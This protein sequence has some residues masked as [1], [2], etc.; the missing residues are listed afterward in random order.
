MRKLSMALALTMILSLCFVFSG[1]GKKSVYETYKAADEKTEAL[2]D[3]DTKVA[4]TMESDGS[5]TPII[6]DLKIKGANTD[7]P[8]M[9]GNVNITV[10][11]M[12]IT[13]GIYFSDE[14]LYMNAYGSKIKQSMSYEDLYKDGDLNSA[15]M[16]E[17]PEEY[18]SD[19]K[20]T[21]VDGG[22]KISFTAD[23][24][25][26]KKS[27]VESVGG[28]NSLFGTDI[29]VDKI[30]ISK[31]VPV[32]LVINDDGYISNYKIS[33]EL[34]APFDDGTG[35][36]TDTTISIDL[37]ITYNNPGSEV[38]IDVPAD[39]DAYQEMT[40]SSIFG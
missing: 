7:T 33:F 18:F 10:M 8:V 6:M 11:G 13:E 40:D 37:D 28:S 15:E 16:V 23:G 29:S 22:K 3:Y 36:T 31:D 34:T 9:S 27:I 12:S 14:V 26:L 2:S 30:K 19:L 38:T 5:S 1:C 21:E 25:T 24:D 39:L 4:L 17:F 35:T 32:E 20:F